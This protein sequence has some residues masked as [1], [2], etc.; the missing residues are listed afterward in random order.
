MGVGVRRAIAAAA[1]N[2]SGIALDAADHLRS[3]LARCILATKAYNMESPWWLHLQRL[4]FRDS[5][6]SVGSHAVGVLPQ[7]VQLLA[8]GTHQ[9]LSPLLLLHQGTA[10]LLCLIQL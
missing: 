5:L 8:Q 2:C 4:L 10:L 1:I 9:V 7:V 3:W 6:T